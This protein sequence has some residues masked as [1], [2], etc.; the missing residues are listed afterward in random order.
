MANGNCT[1]FTLKNAI[2]VLISTTLLVAIIT[3]VYH[4][5]K[6]K[7]KKKHD[8]EIEQ[9]KIE[10]QELTK[11]TEDLEEAKKDNEVELERMNKLNE[12]RRLIEVQ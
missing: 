9:N 1:Y 8:A 11:Q 10:L 12:E 3:F 4:K 6:K 5:N 2:I 7:M